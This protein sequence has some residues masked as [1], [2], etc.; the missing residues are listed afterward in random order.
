MGRRMAVLVLYTPP[1]GPVYHKHGGTGV[2]VG[3][4]LVR[5][6]SWARGF[7]YLSLQVRRRSELVC[8]S[9]H[10]FLAGRLPFLHV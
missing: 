7:L 6:W 2:G 10:S 9:S 3:A 4:L 5:W 8:Q 1:K